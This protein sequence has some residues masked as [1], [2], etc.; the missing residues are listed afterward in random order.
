[1]PRTT[2]SRWAIF[3]HDPDGDM[4]EGLIIGPMRDEGAADTKAEAIRR[5]GEREGRYVECIVLPVD[6][7]AQAARTIA[8]AV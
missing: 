8:S 3:V 7:A 4:G 6:P 2:R 5:A 1:V